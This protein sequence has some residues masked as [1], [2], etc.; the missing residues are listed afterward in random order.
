MTNV[1]CLAT[2]RARRSDQAACRAANL[3]DCIHRAQP[4]AVASSLAPLEP[5]IEE[6]PIPAASPPPIRWRTSKAGNLWCLVGM[7]KFVIFPSKCCDGEFCMRVD[8]RGKPGFFAK[9]TWQ[10]TEEAREWVEGYA[11]DSVATPQPC[12]KELHL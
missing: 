12:G 11:R 9:R 4:R 1:I 7:T 8:E 6:L 10:S 5:V 3:A 2:E